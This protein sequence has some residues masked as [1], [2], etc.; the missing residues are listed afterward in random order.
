MRERDFRRL[1]G[2]VVFA[3]F[4]TLAL[5]TAC[6]TT[7]EVTYVVRSEG[8]PCRDACQTLVGRAAR[9][10]WRTLEVMECVDAAEVVVSTPPVEEGTRVTP[11]EGS[12]LS[13]PVA[14]CRMRTQYTGGIGRRPEGLALA[15][16]SG[17]S[18]AGAYFAR[19][20]Q[21]ERAAA[22]A[23]D[24]LAAELLHHRAPASLVAAA[25]QGIADEERHAAIAARWR[26][27]FG[28]ESASMVCPP[29][30]AVRSLFA[31]ARENV[32]EGCVHETWGAV[33]AAAQAILAAEPVLRADLAAI[34]RDE[35]EHASLSHRID[36][37]ARA[38]L[39]SAERAELD[40]ARVDAVRELARTV[41]EPSD[42]LRGIGM[43]DAEELSRLFEAAC[44]RFGWAA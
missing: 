12:E 9:G 25:R 17:A 41:V 42:D 11:E 24:W 29:R 7:G 18:V 44:A 2:N 13:M 32:V 35:A 38:R 37:W 20:E 5:T 21:L 19:V 16:T 3:A 36:R 43:P 1:V 31:L 10:S 26:A 15:D 6:R 34:A 40:R 22:I 23:F 27:R 14:V 39:S 30:R 4:P 28:G 8:R 33:L